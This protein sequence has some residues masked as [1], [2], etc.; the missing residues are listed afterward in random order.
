MTFIAL[1]ECYLLPPDVFSLFDCLHI[2]N[3]IEIDF[4]GVIPRYKTAGQAAVARQQDG[5]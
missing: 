4:A 5:G 1:E 3:Y 2:K